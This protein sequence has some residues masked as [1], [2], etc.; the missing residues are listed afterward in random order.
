MLDTLQ[1]KLTGLWGRRG[2]VIAAI[3]VATAV[4]LSSFAQVK[5]HGDENNWILTSP[6]GE[7]LFHGDIRNP[8]WDEGFWTLDAPPLAR[9]II[10]AGW[11]VAGG[12]EELDFDLPWDF[13]Q[14]MVANIARGSMP[15]PEIL[16]WSRLPMALLGALSAVLVFLLT[17]QAA[18]WWAGW[19]ALGLFLVNPFIRTSLSRAMSESPLLAFTMLMAGAGFLALRT[20]RKNAPDAQAMSALNKPFAWFILAGALAGLAGASKLNGLALAASGAALVGL[21]AFVDKGSLPRNLRFS[22]AIRT[23]V[24]LVLACLLFFVLLNPFLY[25]DPLGRMVQMYK[26]RVY[27]M[28]IQIEQFPQHLMPQ[29]LA[30]PALL[31]QRTFGTYFALPEVLW[32]L[33][34]L[35]S[36]WGIWRLGTA[37]WNWLRGKAE[38]GEG[39]AAALALLV[40]PV[41]LIAVSLTTPLDWDRYYLLPVVF[42]QVYFAAGVLDLT[43]HLMAFRRR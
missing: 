25:T 24:L 41:P 23:V 43:H 28:G 29:G 4:F 12:I 19:L 5:F 11:Q 17:V 42:A 30:R 22:F 32:P 13:N 9:Y 14:D 1:A 10:N 18:G 21:A 8:L 20:W 15:G 40:T 39:G 37:A 6:Y 35:L 16:W 31:G 38:A 3:L 33:V 26:Y 2:Q 34:M 36:L 7:I 27:E